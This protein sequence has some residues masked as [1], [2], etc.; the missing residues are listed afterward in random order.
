MSHS[1]RVDQLDGAGVQQ[2]L[3]VAVVVETPNKG[4]AQAERSPSCQL[5]RDNRIEAELVVT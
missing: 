4:A 1:A 3:C 2:L 5:A